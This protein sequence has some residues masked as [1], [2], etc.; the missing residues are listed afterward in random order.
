VETGIQAPI[1]SR[2][3]MRPLSAASHW[4]PGYIVR[5]DGHGVA[6][7]WVHPGMAAIRS[8]LP[9]HEWQQA[10][11]MFDPLRQLQVGTR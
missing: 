8:W 11:P 7:E 1:F 9:L 5:A 6:V 4:M 3:Y 10:E 2:M